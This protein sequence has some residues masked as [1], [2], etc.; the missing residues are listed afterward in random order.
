M[1]VDDGRQ[2]FVVVAE[3]DRRWGGL[4]LDG[5]EGELENIALNGP[6]G[7]AGD[8]VGGVGRL[9]EGGA[10]VLAQVE[11]HGVV[12]DSV[13]AVLALPASFVLSPRLAFVGAG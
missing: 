4:L 13:S 5:I 10:A 12:E 9:R 1:I 8:L 7:E 11:R 3:G 6:V 2:G